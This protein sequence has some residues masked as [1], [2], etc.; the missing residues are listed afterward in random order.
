MN[1]YLVWTVSF[2]GLYLLWLVFIAVRSSKQK[3]GSLDQFFLADKKV[4]FLSS[5]LTFWA[6]YFSAAAIIGG[7]GFYYIHGV[8]NFY[9]A[10]IAYCILAVITGTLGKR[11]WLLSRKY[12]EIRS[13]IQL[14]LRH[15]KSPG[16]ETCF[17]VVSLLCLVP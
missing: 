11:F 10:T 4:G 17:V 7:A 1:A 3:K 16:L 6:T 5:T 8:G 9:F 15:F 14:Y 12:P 13:P 2:L